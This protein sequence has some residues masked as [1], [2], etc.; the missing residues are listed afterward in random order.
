M[1]GRLMID[2]VVKKSLMRKYI[3]FALLI[4]TPA[5]FLF[6]FYTG[7]VRWWLND[8]GAGVLYEVFWHIIYMVGFSPLC[9]WVFYGMVLNSLDDQT[10]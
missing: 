5:G 10:V 6:K 1:P 4:V 2:A 7:P 8:Y 9:Y 3:V